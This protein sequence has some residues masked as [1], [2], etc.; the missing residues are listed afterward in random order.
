MHMRVCFQK[1][2]IK[3]WLYDFDCAKVS[4]VSEQSRNWNS[5]SQKQ[6]VLEQ[7][8]IQKELVRHNILINIKKNKENRNAL[9]VFSEKLVF[10]TDSDALW[11]KSRKKRK[12]E[13]N[14]RK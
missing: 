9:Q 7:I 4:F 2:V 8:I 6:K 3:C 12:T 5:T 1:Y 14:N 10:C 11:M 13:Q